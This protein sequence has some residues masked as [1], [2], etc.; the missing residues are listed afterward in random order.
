M[1]SS[2]KLCLAG[3]LLS[4]ALTT[5]VATAG[6]MGPPVKDTRFVAILSGAAIWENAGNTQAFFLASGVEKAYVAD[7]GTNA[8]P[9]GEIF[10]G[11][12]RDLSDKTQGQLGIAVA[13]TGNAKLS[14]QIW[15]D[16]VAE[17]N[18]YTYKY[19][20]Q[21]T[22]IMVKGKL[23]RDTKYQGLQI[24]GNAGLGIGFNESHHFSST[25]TI[26]EALPTP[27]F[28]SNTLSSFTY[29]FGAGIQRAL[30]N[31]WQAGVGY[32][33]ADWGRSQLARIPGQTLNQGLRLN[34]LYTNGV[35]VNVTYL[36]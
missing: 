5:S 32:E 9:E 19:D 8:L 10:L 11:F 29:T 27:G 22:R 20:I 16:A 33:F 7:S 34:H 1:F 6:T 36:A 21:D 17:F 15:D 3:A 2:N 24:Y 26:F 18:N 35:V 13:T 12:Q 4:S 28:E 23:L 14:G 25:P 31:H 30:I